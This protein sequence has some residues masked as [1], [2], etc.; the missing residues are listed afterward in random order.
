MSSVPIVIKDDYE[1]ISSDSLPIPNQF[2]KYVSNVMI[3]SGLIKDRI[4][5]LAIDIYNDYQGKDFLLSCIQKGGM[6]VFSD[7]NHNLENLINRNS[8]K[9]FHYEHE[10]IYASSY[11][12]TISSGKVTIN[13]PNPDKYAGAHVILAEDIVDSGLSMKL[14]VDT[15]KNLEKPP[16]SIAILSL[17]LKRLS[18][19][20]HPESL[21]HLKYVGFEIPNEFVIGYGLDY[22]Q[23]FRNLKP[24]CVINKH[25]EEIY[26]KKN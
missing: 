4:E 19:R 18:D 6:R 14:V 10:N 2:K 3:P 9:E 11:D 5:Q 26:K 22:E 15:L 24:I 12:N 25:G 21:E 1:R 23:Q 8:A 17:L 16:A 20:K 7:V 13:V